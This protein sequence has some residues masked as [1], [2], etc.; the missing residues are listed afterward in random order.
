MEEAARAMD[1]ARLQSP[2]NLACS[3]AVFA[4]LRI[5]F[6][7]KATLVPPFSQPRYAATAASIAPFRAM[8]IDWSQAAS[9]SGM[10]GFAVAVG[11]VCGGLVGFGMAVG[12]GISAVAVGVV[13]VG[14]AV[15]VEAAS[16]A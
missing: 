14:V 7:A 9:P 1:W 6:F 4:L 11:F 13:K 3:A 15:A 12:G 10:R 5:V 2:R 8:D 16:T